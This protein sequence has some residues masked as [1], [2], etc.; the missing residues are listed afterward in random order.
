[1]LQIRFKKKYKN[2][3]KLKKNLYFHKKRFLI[4]SFKKNMFLNCKLT[5]LTRLVINMTLIRLN[6]IRIKNICIVTGK[7]RSI[8]NKTKFK[9]HV[10]QQ[11]LIL[12]KLSNIKKKS[13]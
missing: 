11:Y 1:M 7:Y 8:I 12:N 10:F 3:L 2:I 9:R 4:K 13:W 5:Y 6:S